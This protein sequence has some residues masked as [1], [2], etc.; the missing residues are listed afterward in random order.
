M[1]FTIT[2]RHLVL[3]AVAAALLGTGYGA[4]RYSGG[5]CAGPT[6]RPVDPTPPAPPTPPTPA[7]PADP[8]P[9]KG[10]TGLHLLVVYETGKLLTPSQHGCLFGGD[11]R[12]YLDSRC[13]KGVN[14]WP[15]Y[16][17]WDPSTD[18][19]GHGAHWAAAMAVPRTA[20]PYYVVG[21]GTSWERGELGAKTPAEFLAILKKY[22]EK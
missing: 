6:P 8:G 18:P 3:A 17:V 12:G 5:G 19:A 2:L 4:G 13:P 21:N 22:G 9:F 1:T 15:E 11:V 10:T 14:G 16:R 7:P 20:L